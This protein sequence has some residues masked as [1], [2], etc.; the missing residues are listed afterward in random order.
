[1]SLYGD[2]IKEREGYDIVENEKGFA[3]FSV[4]GVE[5]YLRDLYVRPEFRKEGVASALADEVQKRAKDMGA[6]ILVG[7]VCSGMNGANESIKV[8][9]AYGMKLCGTNND[10][11][12]FNKE[13]L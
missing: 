12:Y 6:T 9:Q 2:Y 7:S 13:I 5:C 8:L 10:F 1:M 11:I 4:Q 3:T